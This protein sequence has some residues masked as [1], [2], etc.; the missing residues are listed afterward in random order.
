MAQRLLSPSTLPVALLTRWRPTAVRW[1]WSTS[2][3]P[4]RF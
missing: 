3:R 2:G 4:W 1:C